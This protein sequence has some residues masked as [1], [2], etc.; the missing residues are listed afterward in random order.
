MGYTLYWKM[1]ALPSSH[2][3]QKVLTE[4]PRLRLIADRLNGAPIQL[5]GLEEGS[6]P[7]FSTESIF[8]NGVGWE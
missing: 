8:F 7:V 5:Q 1:L 4:I 3:I 6:Q 2:A